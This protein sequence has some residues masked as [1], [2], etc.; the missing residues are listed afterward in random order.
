MFGVRLANAVVPPRATSRVVWSEV[1][2]AL[3]PES[4]GAPRLVQHRKQQSINNASTIVVEGAPAHHFD[5][6]GLAGSP[7]LRV[8]YRSTAGKQ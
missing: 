6:R 7:T 1:L 3:C 4:G 2:V 5:R 8:R